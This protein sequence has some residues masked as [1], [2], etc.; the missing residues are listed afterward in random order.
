MN[1][2]PTGSKI[3]VEVEKV[4]RRTQSGL[5]IPDQVADR[6]DMSQMT[7]TVVAMGPLAFHDQPIPWCTVGDRVKFSK[8]A[9]YLHKEADIDYRVFSDLDI[10]MVERNDE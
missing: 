5:Y 2:Q 1:W 9:G 7:G 4:E 8:Y 6:Q 3:M 10:I